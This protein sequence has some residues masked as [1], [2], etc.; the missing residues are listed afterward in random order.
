MVAY[1]TLA[2]ALGQADEVVAVVRDQDWPPITFPIAPEFTDWRDVQRA[3]RPGLE[4]MDQSPQMPQ[5]FMHGSDLNDL[6][7]SISPNTFKNF[8]A[9][10]AKQMI[11]V[12]KDGYLIGDGILFF[13][14]EGDE[15]RVLVGHHILI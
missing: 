4:F 14:S 8:Q 6:L 12:N 10:R 2:H 7:A 3:W 15:G 5:L 13:N 9:G 11:A 1:Q